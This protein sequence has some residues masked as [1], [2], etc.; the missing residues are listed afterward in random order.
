MVCPVDAKE[1]KR[2]AALFIRWLSQAESANTHVDY[3]KAATK[4]IEEFVFESAI[5]NQRPW[6]TCFFRNASAF[7]YRLSVFYLT[8]LW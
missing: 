8:V 1:I 2:F 6:I 5:G 4:N 7:Y 3:I